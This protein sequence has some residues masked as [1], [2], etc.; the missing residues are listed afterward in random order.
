MSATIPILNAE[1]FGFIS[2][3]VRNKSA[4][5]LD[6]QKA[7]LVQSRLS[8][9]LRAH[10]FESFEDLVVELKKPRSSFLVQE[11][12]E[13]MTTNETSFF[14]DLHPFNALRS[15]VLPDLIRRRHNERSLTIW[16]NACSSGQEPYTIAML[17][18]EYFP[19]I[20]GWSLRILASDICSKVLEKAKAAEFNQTEVNRGLPTQFLLKYF[21]RSGMKWII[22]EDI[23]QMVDFRLINLVEPWPDIPVA[24]IAF[25]RN[26]LIYFDIATKQRILSKVHKCLRSDGYLFLGG[27]ESTMGFETAYSRE[28]IGDA[29]CY[30]PL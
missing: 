16:S 23:R 2:L 5:V 11:V 14:R 27:S 1:T 26:V 13:A 22:N 28:K 29:V 19:E 21:K 25:L 18:R 15:Q 24:D 3:M 6:D 20:T 10:G 30:R 12:V 8:P 9:I 7:Y 17:L 4:I